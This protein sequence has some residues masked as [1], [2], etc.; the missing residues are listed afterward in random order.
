MRLSITVP[1]SNNFEN[2]LEDRAVLEECGLESTQ[3]EERSQT[4]LAFH[5][6]KKYLMMVNGTKCLKFFNTRKLM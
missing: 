4:H 2:N 3:K 6:I 1:M 5:D